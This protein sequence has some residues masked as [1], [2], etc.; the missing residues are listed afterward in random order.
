M[1]TKLRFSATAIAIRVLM[2]WVAIDVSMA[3]P[4]EWSMPVRHGHDRWSLM[5]V[6]VSHGPHLTS[7]AQMSAFDVGAGAANM[8][9]RGMHCQWQATP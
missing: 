5:I 2:P 9:A 6:F 4:C 3:M 1:T 8:D 7:V